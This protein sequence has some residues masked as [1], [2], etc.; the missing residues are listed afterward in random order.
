MRI[1]AV[2]IGLT[3]TALTKGS[4]GAHASS[5]EGE[6]RA[7][8]ALGPWQKVLQEEGITLFLQD[9]V[10]SQ[11]NEVRQ[12]KA[13]FVIEAPID[14]I[15]RSLSSSEDIKHWFAGAS[16]SKELMRK[17]NEAWKAEVVFSLPWPLNKRYLHA[18]FYAQTLPNGNYAIYLCD[19]G[20]LEGEG[21]QLRHFYGKWEL[22]SVDEHRTFLSYTSF[23]ESP[24]KVPRF[25]MDPVIQRSI[26]DSMQNFKNHLED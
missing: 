4:N 25:I 22:K 8:K 23:S 21:I 5:I 20:E 12:S 18:Q 15:C 6:F 26:M 24:A 16:S 10:T 3:L 1:T 9:I 11:K 19:A 17:H 7:I 2:L 14:R 13:V